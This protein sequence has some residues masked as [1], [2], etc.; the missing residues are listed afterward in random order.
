MSACVHGNV[1]RA[2]MRMFNC[3]RP[4]V[5]TCPFGCRYFIEKLDVQDA[6]LGETTINKLCDIVMELTKN[7][8]NRN[9]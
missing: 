1:C 7:K 8:E 9:A 2:W 3:S 6:I 4:L 5:A